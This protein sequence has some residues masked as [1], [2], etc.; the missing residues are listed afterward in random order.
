MVAFLFKFI[1]LIPE[2][3]KICYNTNDNDTGGQFMLSRVYEI[4]RASFHLE[5]AVKN[6]DFKAFKK[7]YDL[8]EKHLKEVKD[9]FYTENAHLIKRQSE[10]NVNQMKYKEINELDF[11]VKPTCID[12]VYEGNY[13]EHFCEERT[14]QLKH[15]RA[16]ECHNEFWLQHQTVHGNI[17]GSVPV[18][19]M[20]D[21]TAEALEKQGWIRVKVH[22]LDFGRVKE[23]QAIIDYCDK[24][25]SHYII[26]VEKTTGMYLVLQYHIKK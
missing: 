18:E 20:P 4:R 25:F 11:L 17:F 24:F 6:G 5:E 7:Q 22:I 19:L 13:I 21:D 12:N 2:I 14:E 15:A 8:I 26:I 16:F 10:T 23:K 1:F 9:I 3:L